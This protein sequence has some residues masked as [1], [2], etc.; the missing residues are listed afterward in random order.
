[1][2]MKIIIFILFSSLLSFSLLGQNGVSV[3]A[4]GKAIDGLA[5][6]SYGIAFSLVNVET[7]T[8]YY[9]ELLSV[10]K[11]RHS[12]I[13]NLPPGKYQIFYFGG[14]A[15]VESDENPVHQ[16]FGYFEFEA[17]KSYYLGSFIGKMKIG[18]YGH[19]PITY[20][21][22]N[23]EIPKKVMKTLKKRKLIEND[24]EIR[25]TYPYNSDTLRIGV[26]LQR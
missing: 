6:I 15:I 19:R 8:I 9:S 26:D 11:Q 2:I 4:S 25:K 3:T 23:D 5:G 20:N 10:F 16:Y 7:G 17:G 18:K 12:I 22:K 21:I 13:E 14:S 1:M 24:E